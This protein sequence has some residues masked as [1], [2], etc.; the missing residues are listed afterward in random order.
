[1]IM[2]CF[3]GLFS[4]PSFAP[5]QPQGYYNM[6]HRKGTAKRTFVPARLSSA[7]PIPPQKHTACPLPFLI[8]PKDIRPPG[9]PGWR[10]RRQLP[11]YQPLRSRYLP[12]L[13]FSGE[14]TVFYRNSSRTPPSSISSPCPSKASSS[15]ASLLPFTHVPLVEPMSLTYQCSPLRFRRACLRLTAG[16]AKT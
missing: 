5:V 12:Y 3:G 11:I 2:Y 6:P 1:M 15:A 10:N 13:N 7:V 14:P 9:S 4:F 16:S 8:F